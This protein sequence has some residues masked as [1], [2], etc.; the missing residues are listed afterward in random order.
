MVNPSPLPVRKFKFKKS[1]SVVLAKI[2]SKTEEKPAT[3]TKEEEEEEEEENHFQHVSPHNVNRPIKVF[4]PQIPTAETVGK[5]LSTEAKVGATQSTNSTASSLESS[6]SSAL[7]AFNVARNDKQNNNQAN[8]DVD[9][10]Q[11]IAAEREEID[12]WQRMVSVQEEAALS[13]TAHELQLAINKIKMEEE[14]EEELLKQQELAA[15]MEFDEAAL[16]QKEVVKEEMARLVKYEHSLEELTRTRDEEERQR[17]E[18]HDRK[19]LMHRQKEDL[20]Q[21]KLA[22]LTELAQLLSLHH[23]AMLDERRTLLE[24][25]FTLDLA[26]RDFSAHSSYTHFSLT[27]PPIEPL[28]RSPYAPEV[29]HDEDRS[30]QIHAIAP[31]PPPMPPPISSPSFYSKSWNGGEKKKPME[32][33]MEKTPEKM[34]KNMKPI[35]VQQQAVNYTAPLDEDFMNHAKTMR[36]AATF[37]SPK[38]KSGLRRGGRASIASVKHNGFHFS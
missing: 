34:S 3:T 1:A 37:T 12:N 25:R 4:V 26:L 21:Q 24:K 27:D 7:A 29:P 8:N 35:V 32:E 19:D 18:E 30:I 16:K 5:P 28:S 23:H 11:R 14:E 15:Q 22:E 38:E 33:P 36:P 13:R 31:M 20:Y 6:H 10:F 2:V 17:R 9:I